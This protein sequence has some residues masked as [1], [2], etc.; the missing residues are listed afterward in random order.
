MP[1]LTELTSAK[2]QQ[3]KVNP[4]TVIDH[5]RKQHVLHLSA[6]EIANAASCFPIFISRNNQNGDWA[7]SAMTSLTLNQNL[8]VQG[9]AWQSV[10]QPVTMRTYPLYLM[11][12]PDGSDSYCVGF[13]ESSNAFSYDHGKSLFESDGQ[14]SAHLS[15]V[16]QLLE[17]QLK[18]IQQTYLFAQKLE[19]LSLLKEMDLKIVRADGQ[20]DTIKG[21]HTID[22]D[23]LRTLDAQL[24]AELNTL[25]YL[26][27]IHAMLLS[28]Y[29]LNVLINKHNVFNE[30]QQITNVKMEVSKE[31]AH[32]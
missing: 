22:E 25:G 2:H 17:T 3:L 20:V 30:N 15:M 32:I 31:F 14:A 4:Q 26:I 5:A 7:F 13:D 27:P 6:S 11:Q 28:I 18:D 21:L 24:L 23:K 19:E 29:Q 10:F 8:F 16:T 1:S 12:K 9:N